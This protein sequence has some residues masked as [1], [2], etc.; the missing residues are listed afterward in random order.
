[1]GPRFSAFHALEVRGLPGR[2]GRQGA[3]F[4]RP[5]SGNGLCWSFADGFRVDDVGWDTQDGIS[6]K[7]VGKVV[8]MTAMV[9]N[10]SRTIENSRSA[11]FAPVGAL[12][13]MG[14]DY[15]CVIACSKVLFWR[16]GV[17]GCASELPSILGRFA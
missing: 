3:Q 10:L 1:E 5:A 8:T 2:T 13:R 7:G 4:D 9:G 17:A 15:E 6:H 11:D 14:F 16:A 12:Q